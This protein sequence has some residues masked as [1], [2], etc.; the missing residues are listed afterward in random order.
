MSGLLRS[1]ALALLAVLAPLA[2]AAPANPAPTLAALIDV[3]LRDNKDLQAARHAVDGA[4]ARLQQA[5]LG[6]NP[7]LELA[8]R[9]DTLFSND[10]EYAVSAGFSQEFPVAGR[11]ARQQDVARVDVAL[12][13]VE[14][15]QAERALA[16]NI[17]AAYYRL[18]ALDRQVE[19]QDRLIGVDN[20][21]LNVTR[22]RLRAAEVAETDVTTAQ[23]EL[24]R[25]SEQRALLQTQRA[26]QLA[27]LNQLLGRAGDEALTIDDTLPAPGALPDA[28][29]LQ[30]Q[31]LASRPDLRA[32]YLNADRARAE[33]ALA[34][35]ERWEDWTV[36]VGVEQDRLVLDGA[37]PQQASRAIGVS[38]S[39]PLPLR[40][41]RQGR[42]AEA[43]A[44][45]AQANA[46]VQ[47]LN[48]SIAS[49]ITRRHSEVTRLAQSLANYQHDLLPDAAHNVALVQQAYRQGLTPIFTVIQAQRQQADVTQADLDV[50]DRYLQALAALHTA[51]ATYTQ[52]VALPEA[53]ASAT[54]PEGK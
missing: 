17:A 6:P 13:L 2:V 5:G 14:I 8:G 18:L 48:F 29:T 38:L 39:I 36:G 1:C 3:A 40:N 16:G 19:A 20:A 4:R 15:A 21:L 7:R 33:Q 45:G 53:S 24:R 10:G 27:E 37:P 46:S 9:N 42:I 28:A 52:H 26:T 41:N 23:L 44:A 34:R 50:L 12:A 51:A 11:L 49:E 22:D 30:R 47:A 54:D 31:A 25:A 43:L 35:A 32:A